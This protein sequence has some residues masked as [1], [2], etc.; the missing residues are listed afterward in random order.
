MH[1]LTLLAIFAIVSPALSSAQQ[2]PRPLFN[3][4]DLEGW[5]FFLEDPAAKM[6]DVWSVSDGVLVCK[7]EPKGYL[8]TKDVFTSFRLVVEWQWPAGATPGNSGVLLRLAKEPRLLPR[9]Y[10]SQLKHGNAG[11]I[12]GFQGMP[13]TGDPARLKKVPGHKV[14]G[15]LTG[16]SKLKDAEKAPGEWNRYEI[17]FN[18]GDLSL[19]IN[20]EK[21]NEAHDCS[22][23]PGRIALQSEGGEV[24]FRKV[25]LTPLAD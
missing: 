2:A 11:D 6:A 16:V 10:E 4:K 21:V 12:Y 5:E 13:L 3:G 18:K 15:D 17:V 20:G 1:R 24:H 8:C 22:V 7:G 19:S 9:C 23:T 25:E 14:G